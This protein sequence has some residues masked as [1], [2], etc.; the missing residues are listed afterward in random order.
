MEFLL[1]QIS[2]LEAFQLKGLRK[3]SGMVATCIDRS[4]TNEEVFRQANLQ[5]AP[6]SPDQAIRCMQAILQQRRLALVGSILREGND[7][8][9]IRMVSFHR[10]SAAPSAALHR[11]GP[12]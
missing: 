4:N 7:H 2:R 12:T 3:I 5:I 8:P 1:S 6:R 10:N 11:S 9:M